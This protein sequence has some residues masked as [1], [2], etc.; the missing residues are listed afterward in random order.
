MKPNLSSLL[1][2][3]YVHFTMSAGYFF[4][5]RSATC[6]FSMTA[7]DAE[8]S[9]VKPAESIESR[10]MPGS[11]PPIGANPDTVARQTLPDSGS[12]WPSSSADIFDDLDWEIESVPQ[13]D[14]KAMTEEYL[15]NR[16]TV[17]GEKV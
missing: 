9:E 1:G 3:G 7:D 8:N 11:G 15:K 10:A 6:V 13:D 2:L 4:K 14:A 5:S 17:M 12:A 16:R